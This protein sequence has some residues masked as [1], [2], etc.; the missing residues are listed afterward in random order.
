MQIRDEYAHLVVGSKT[1]AG[2]QG[3]SFPERVDQC[4]DR[5]L[6]LSPDRHLL[7]PGM[8][9]GHLGERAI[10][11]VM[12]WP[13]AW[14]TWEELFKFVNLCVGVVTEMYD[15]GVRDFILMNELNL[16]DEGGG[17]TKAD[18]E[19][20]NSFGTVAHD[21][22]RQRLVDSGRGGIRL[23]GPNF[24]PG[25]GEDENRFSEGLQSGYDLCAALLDRCDVI[26]THHYGHDASGLI[27]APDASW[28]AC[29][30]DRVR[31]HLRQRGFKQPFA[32]TEF[33]HP[34]TDL[35][36]AASVSRYLDH[37]ENYYRWLN[38]QDDVIAAVHFL[39]T[40]TDVR[41]Q[42]YTFMRM[43]GAFDRLGRFD[44]NSE[45]DGS[46]EPA[47]GPVPGGYYQMDERGFDS[48]FTE[49]VSTTAARRK[50]QRSNEPSTDEY[51]IVRQDFHYFTT[52]GN[53][54]DGTLSVSASSDMDVNGYAP[55]AV[56]H[57][58]FA[59]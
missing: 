39:A 31:V 36:N 43:P 57:A 5:V 14:R 6:V 45:L 35:L 55:D 33:N 12:H 56:Y 58:I 59:V 37:V 48:R 42:E 47:P 7:G 19:R 10:V 24:S 34:G 18:Y 1:G 8:P 20:I 4:F 21:H 17:D 26:A 44:R 25:H 46:S 49:Y 54:K 53:R 13:D 11:R 9:L 23:W 51:G 16:T 2:I 32:V 29:R 52:A 40:N 15:W 41:F 3:S 27:E 38:G 50:W 30:L 22:V 28:Y